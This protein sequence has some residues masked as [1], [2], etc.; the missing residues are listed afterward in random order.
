MSQ[1]QPPYC[2]FTYLEAFQR[3]PTRAEPYMAVTFFDDFL[4]RKGIVLVRG[5]FSGHLTK[6][7]ASRLLRLTKHYYSTDPKKVE[8]FNRRPA[9]FDVDAYFAEC[10]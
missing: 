4:E 2:L 5:D 9:E 10:P 7:D 1:F 8:E 6:E 3:D